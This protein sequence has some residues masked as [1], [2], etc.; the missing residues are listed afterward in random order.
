MNHDSPSRTITV[1]DGSI[2]S[3]RPIAPEDRALLEVA[4]AELS[5][6]SRYRRFLSPMS[7]LSPAQLDYLID[8]D[9]HDHE[10]VIALDEGAERL[11]GVARYVRTAETVAEPAVAV[12]DDWQ[13]RGVGTALLDALVERA[14]ASGITSFLGYVLVDN[15][16]PLRLLEEVGDITVESSGGASQVE[17]H[18]RRETPGRLRMLLRAV[19]AGALDPGLALWQRNG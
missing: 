1:P 10:A 8:V 14:I 5:D 12:A 15:P 3:I 16:A 7:N 2:I 19:A 17:V 4:F 11:I 13:R 9:H 18:L 6:E